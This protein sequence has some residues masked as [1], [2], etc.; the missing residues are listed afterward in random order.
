M[1]TVVKSR[2]I[3]VRG[4]YVISFCVLAKNICYIIMNLSIQPLYNTTQSIYFSTFLNIA[5]A[6]NNLSCNLSIFKFI[7]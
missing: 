1:G 7:D 5:I 4:K 3:P 6:E 2:N